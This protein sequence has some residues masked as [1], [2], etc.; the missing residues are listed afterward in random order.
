MTPE[1]KNQIMLQRK[2]KELL[3]R[4]RATPT[5]SP[6][7]EER[8]VSDGMKENLKAAS[9]WAGV[10]SRRTAELTQ[11]GV[12]AAAEKAKEVKATVD[13]KRARSAEEKVQATEAKSSPT[14]QPTEADLATK[15]LKGEDPGSLVVDGMAQELVRV[16]GEVGEGKAPFAEMATEDLVDALSARE[17]A[18]IAVE[19][20]AVDV[21]EA[22][23][24]PGVTE[25]PP[26]V[27]APRFSPK[28]DALRISQQMLSKSCR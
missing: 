26:V 3:E 16:D 15:S 5:A 20:E 2:R 4:A 19:T 23:L 13:A 25:Q 7:Q 12:A 28:A 27:E 11:K 6:T 1:E 18:A 22:N 17:R 14:V 9:H 8:L 24:E 21:S 10:I